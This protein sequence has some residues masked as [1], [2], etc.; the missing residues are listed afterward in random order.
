MSS[1]ISY[2][3]NENFIEKLADHLCEAGS[4]DLSSVACVFTGNR[5]GLFLK[6]ALSARIKKSHYPPKTFSMDDF[7]RYI[8]RNEPHYKR[9]GSLDACRMIWELCKEIAP[10]VLKGKEQFSRFLPWAKEMILF[11]ERLDLEDVDDKTLLE[12]KASAAIG[13]PVP[14][15]INAMLKKIV[16]IR[17]AFHDG[18]EEQ[19][20]YSRGY[21]Y[22]KAAKL[23]RNERFEEFKKIIFCNFFYLQQTELSVVKNAV[24]N[25]DTEILLQGDQEKWSVLSAFAKEIGR[26]IRS[27]SD[28][29]KEPEIK[30]YS[31]VDG[32][33]QVGIARQILSKVK[34]HGNTVV[35]VPDTSNLMPLL[36]EVSSV[37]KELNVSAGYPIT[38]ST[39]YGLFTG[40]FE[41]Q[42][43]KNNKGYYF[44][45]YLKV[46][47]H[48]LSKNI[49]FDDED[50][51][52]T[53]IIV[54]TIEEVLTGEIPSTVSGSIF[55]GL[56]EL[57]SSEEVYLHS[58]ET[59][60]GMGLS[61]SRKRIEGIVAGLHKLLFA[62]WE[63]ISSVNELI[64]PLKVL[65]DTLV[66][67]S[68]IW[69]YK[70]NISVA[71]KI[72][73]LIEELGASTIAGEKF[74]KEQLFEIFEEI[75][76]S[77]SIDFQGTPLKGLQI[78]GLNQTHSLNF[79]NVVI[80]DVNEGKL[81]NIPQI[82]PLIPKEV[83]I[84][85]KINR[86]EKEE[87][88]QRYQ[89]MRLISGAKRVHL[90]YRDDD[91]TERSRYI[92]ELVWKK[93][94]D[95]VKPANIDVLP[96][97]VNAFKFAALPSKNVIE[98]TS[99][100]AEMIKGM[101]FSATRID[102]YMNCPKRFYY[103]YVL[104]LSEKEDIP[105]E[106]ESVDVGDFLHK[107]LYE[108]YKGFVKEKPVISKEFKKT[109][110]AKFEKM[111]NET[112]LRKMKSDSF[113]L[114]EVM[115]ARMESFLSCESA[116]GVE[117]ILSLEQEYNGKIKTSSNAFEFVAKVDRV[118]VLQGGEL[119]I[120]DYKTGAIKKPSKDIEALRNASGREA[121]KKAVV[122]FQLPIYMEVLSKIEE[123]F[124]RAFNA[125]LYGIRDT[126]L[127]SLWKNENESERKEL[128]ALYAK[129]LRDILEEAIDPKVP[130]LP[131]EE[132]KYCS[133]CPY[134]Y[135]CR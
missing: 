123:F 132:E 116:R 71:D 110:Y 51:A 91:E 11:I 125:A 85:L 130:F 26:E 112:F 81:P 38:R 39:L 19:K 30:L 105:E 69:S 95:L 124:G 109:F 103:Q 108:A 50:E 119:L 59:L 86:A 62:D 100:M 121:I 75:A 65:L 87:E 40:I 102:C 104:K 122:S 45:D 60:K 43:R 12:V 16:K 4:S 117:K 32:V 22:H 46:L 127:I 58:M 17:K 18:M 42:K 15:Q 8:L 74:E 114:K 82:E 13:Y 79:E 36:A 67:K 41:A 99:S 76:A 25:T 31:G 2:G 5:Q 120:V 20:A 14:D 92:E 78:L 129:L 34:D 106:M 10:Q 111:F 134:F 23:S 57:Q 1:V 47:S 49:R 107:L 44:K 70:L 48:P 126:E 113:M 128:T 90:I 52:A 115:I 101:R 96:V 118:D 64:K 68:Y 56:E 63:G 28:D 7:V 84:S 77:Y 135:M 6:R 33:S 94:K 73:D 72:Y 133:N 89:F 27:L 24:K 55:V 131:D 98:K 93:Q 88:I 61:V 37:A 21:E 29:M 54:H 97:S 80:L 53:R 35:V 9:L 83:L 3:L 66:H